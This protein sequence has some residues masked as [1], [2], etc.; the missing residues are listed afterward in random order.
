MSWLYMRNFAFCS[1]LLFSASSTVTCNLEPEKLQP[2]AENQIN[3]SRNT[4]VIQG[5]LEQHTEYHHNIKSESQWQHSEYK[6]VKLEDQGV[7]SEQS[8]TVKPHTITS[9]CRT[10]KPNH[11]NE[12]LLYQ[13]VKFEAQSV[14]SVHPTGV[15]S[16]I[17]FDPSIAAGLPS[18]ESHQQSVTS[19]R[20]RLNS[21]VHTVRP[22]LSVA[23]DISPVNQS[24]TLEQNQ[25]AELHRVK[26]EHQKEWSAHRQ[27]SELCR[28]LE[29]QPKERTIVQDKFE[30]LPKEQSIVLDKLAT[31]C[32]EQSTVPGKFESLPKEQSMVKDQLETLSKEQSILQDK[33]ETLPR[34]QNIVQDKELDTHDTISTQPQANTI[35]I[36]EIQVPVSQVN[37][38]IQTQQANTPSF[39]AT[40]VLPCQKLEVS[41]ITSFSNDIT[42]TNNQQIPKQDTKRQI[43]I[44]C[45]VC[46]MSFN[47]SADFTSHKES[48][49]NVAKSH[50]CGICEKSFPTFKEMFVHIKQHAKRKM[51]KCKECGQMF[52]FEK[53]LRKHLKHIHAYEM[54]QCNI[55]GKIFCSGAGLGRHHKL[56]NIKCSKCGEKFSFQKDLAKHL[57]EHSGETLF[58]CYICKQNFPSSS[59]LNGHLQVHYKKEN[60]KHSKYKKSFP[61][62]EQNGA[63]ELQNVVL[64]QETVN[65]A[66]K[67][68]SEQDDTHEDQ[69]ISMLQSTTHDSEDGIL[70]AQPLL[71][72]LG[73]PEILL[74]V[75]Q[76]N[77]AENTL[78]SSS[79]NAPHKA[80]LQDKT[81]ECLVC[82]KK[83]Y[84]EQNLKH[85]HTEHTGEKAFQCDICK[86]K[87]STF[88]GSRAHRKV[89]AAEQCTISE[90]ILFKSTRLETHYAKHTGEKPFQCNFCN[91]NFVTPSG[92]CRHKKSHTAE[93]PQCDA[94][95]KT[96]WSS[97]SLSKHKKL[98]TGEKP[99]VCEVCGRAFSVRAILVRH[100]RTHTGEKPYQCDICD[101]WFAGQETLIKHKRIHTS[102][103]LYHCDECGKGYTSSYN[104]SN[105]KKTHSGENKYVCDICGK[106]FSHL[107]YIKI[108][109]QIHTGEKPYQCEVCGK[110]FSTPQCLH[111]HTKH[112]HSDDRPYECDVCHKKFKQSSHLSRHKII[113]T[114]V[115]PFQCTVCDR[116][117]TQA[118]N[119]NS[120]MKTQHGWETNVS[121][122]YCGIVPWCWNGL[123]YGTSLWA[124]CRYNI[125]N[126]CMGCFPKSVGAVSSFT[127][128]PSI[129]W[130]PHESWLEF[131]FLDFE[132]LHC[133]TLP[134]CSGPGGV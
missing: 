30:T 134:K 82:G 29:T 19:E 11:Q 22:N 100:G 117:F 108:H 65:S 62:A 21:E 13:N 103:K 102:Q 28:T 49:G 26:S 15:F 10:F 53:D 45:D 63:S 104:L 78:S 91:K 73:K 101:K 20:L 97:G 48:H 79:V 18:V 42:N 111:K 1:L 84:L 5:T 58:Q 94:C 35:E 114:G 76:G 96:F 87:F 133:Y 9:D 54:F 89:H 12:M 98:H 123:H 3:T 56:H 14:T 75:H 6:S 128:K 95:G 127:V 112:T 90:K 92:L 47:N 50:R 55:C 43:L 2:C 88:K 119:L 116:T 80:H 57:S 64:E 105:H 41:G 68:Y 7:T 71:S 23:P 38:T 74:A 33:L 85:H 16:N 129:L 46:Q 4:S 37:P 51:H 124:R 132:L 32:K 17:T 86:K 66:P 77:L 115:K 70:S 106:Q 8:V 44:Q 52:Y 83:F 25:V 72:K 122:P 107:S 60:H 121:W 69:Q 125:E 130:F 27:S 36:P 120:H 39:N 131:N 31:L 67:E 93:R 109:Q 59:S 81:H 24:V 110:S 126:T 34:E 61:Y 99:H 40:K 118:V 113:H